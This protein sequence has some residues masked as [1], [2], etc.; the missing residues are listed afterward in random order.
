MPSIIFKE[1]IYRRVKNL[2]NRNV[3]K[4]KIEVKG[5]LRFQKTKK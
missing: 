5:K 2:E 1:Q 4:K 3:S